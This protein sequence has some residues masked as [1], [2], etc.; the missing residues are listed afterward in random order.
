MTTRSYQPSPAHPVE[1]VDDGGQWSLAFTREFPQRPE[2]VWSALTEPDE[3]REWAPYTADRPLTSPGP[4]TLIMLD[5]DTNQEL[6]GRISRA[7]RPTLLEYTWA[8]QAL[9]WALTETSTGTRLRLTHQLPDRAQGAMMAAGW[10][11][12]LDVAALLLAGTPIGP[13]VGPKALDYGWRDLNRQYSA[14]LGLEPIE[15]PIEN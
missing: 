13:I 4:V 8:D 9:C 12:C 2:A 14:E 1:L 5:G 6:P 3:L 10:H 7:E 15:P 11:L